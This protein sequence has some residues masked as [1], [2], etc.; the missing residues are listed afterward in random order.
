MIKNLLNIR[1][2]NVILIS[3]SALSLNGCANVGQDFSASEVASIHIGK[4]TQND[5]RGKFG[6]PWRVGLED[7]TRTWT[8]GIYHYSLFDKSTS[9][10][11]VV[12]FDDNNTVKSYSFNST[13]TNDVKN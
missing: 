5:I 11:L 13:D 6:T 12:R 1:T 4:S 2:I 10:D 7:G 9:R 8:Y 3:S